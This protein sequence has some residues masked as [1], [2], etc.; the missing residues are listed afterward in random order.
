MGPKE[1]FH[2][3]IC[4]VHIQTHQFFINTAAQFLSG[5]DEVYRHNMLSPDLF[6]FIYLF[7]YESQ[8]PVT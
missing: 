8:V 6:I 5:L 3:V 1:P 7:V 4:H 2:S